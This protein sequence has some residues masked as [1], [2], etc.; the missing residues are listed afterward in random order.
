MKSGWVAGNPNG[1][2]WRCTLKNED[3]TEE[4]ESGD[5]ATGATSF[6]LDVDPQQI[7][8]CNVYNSFDYGGRRIALTKVDSPVQVRGDLGGPGSSVTSTFTVTNPGTSALNTVELTDDKCTPQYQSGDTGDD[9]ILDNDPAETWIYTCTR[10]LTSSPGLSPAIVT[11]DAR[12]GAVD[13]AGTAV[14]DY[15]LGQGGGVRPGDHVDEDT[16]RADGEPWPSDG[17]DLHL[18]RHEHGQHEIDERH[19]EGRSGSQRLFTGDAGQCNATDRVGTRRVA[20]VL[21]H[22]PAHRDDH[23]SDREHRRRDRHPAVPGHAASWN[24]RPQ[25]SCRRSGPRGRHR[26]PS[27]SSTRN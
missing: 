15:C 4:L 24:H 5:F 26:P 2:D 21:L 6:R 16:E 9:G 20:G 8:T 23:R 10:V 7:I 11:N 17:R 14:S 1:D 13:P 12:V 27:P 25:R 3:G 18:R 19:G 22:D